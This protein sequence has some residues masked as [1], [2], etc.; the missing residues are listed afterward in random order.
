MHHVEQWQST[1]SEIAGDR[2]VLPDKVPYDAP[3]HPI[4][5]KSC[6]SVRVLEARI[7]CVVSRAVDQADC[8]TDEFVSNSAPRKWDQRTR[9]GHK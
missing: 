1:V 9:N 5:R 6:M 7:L 3:C 8:P 2:R 4:C